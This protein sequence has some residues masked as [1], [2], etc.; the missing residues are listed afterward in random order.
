MDTQSVDGLMSHSVNRTAPPTTVEMQSSKKGKKPN[1]RRTLSFSETPLMPYRK[2]P[3]MTMFEYKETNVYTLADP[4]VDSRLM[5]CFWMI[6]HALH[7]E[8]IPMWEGFNS[9]ISSDNLPRQ[10]V[11]YMPNLKEPITSLSVVERTLVTTQKCAEE[12]HQ[13]F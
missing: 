1:K 10:E 8:T 6:I 3:K 7:I 13:C 5:D 2:V 12:C 11:R 9:K 4:T